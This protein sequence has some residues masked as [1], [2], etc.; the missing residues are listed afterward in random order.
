MNDETSINIPLMQEVKL[1]YS[2]GRGIKEDLEPKHRGGIVVYL[3]CSGNIMLS[4]LAG[5]P[6]LRGGTGSLNKQDP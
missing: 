1:K 4:G 2:V 6:V 5:G 3:A